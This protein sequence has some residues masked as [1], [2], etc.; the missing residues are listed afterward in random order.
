VRVGGLKQFS[1][2][3]FT[4]DRCDSWKG[5]KFQPQKFGPVYVEKHIGD[6][7]NGD[8]MYFVAH[9]RKY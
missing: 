4:V 6:L 2:G 5:W 8:P 1:V 7:C 9:L 3:K